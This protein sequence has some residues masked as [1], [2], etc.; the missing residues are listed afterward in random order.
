MAASELSFPCCFPTDCAKK[1]LYTWLL[2][3]MEIIL[4]RL[5]RMSIM[6]DLM[7]LCLDLKLFQSIAILHYLKHINLTSVILS[8]KFYM[9]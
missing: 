2:T 5:D 1:H 3:N 4:Y 6:V 8:V 9:E 7:M